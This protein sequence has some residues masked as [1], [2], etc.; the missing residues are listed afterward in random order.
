MVLNDFGQIAHH[1]WRKLHERFS[2]MDLN[3]FQIMPNHMHGIILL[4][5][6]PIGAGLA[7][8]HDNGQPARDNGD[9]AG[10]STAP[11][12]PTTFNAIGNIVGAYKSS[13]ANECLEIFKQ[14]HPGEIMG[15][16]WQ[17]N[18]HEHIIRTEAAYLNIYHYILNNPSNWKEDTFNK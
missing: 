16:I 4:N 14:N 18:F 10:A 13:V 3:V 11:T 8:A 1:H 17:R 7:P 12:G 5:D 6:F 2:N 9:R 15:K